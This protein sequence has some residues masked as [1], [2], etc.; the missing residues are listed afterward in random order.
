M[1]FSKETDYASFSVNNLAITKKK[2][3]GLELVVKK[4]NLHSSLSRRTEEV[5]DLVN[6]YID[7]LNKFEIPVPKIIE[8]SY[9]GRQLVYVSKFEGENLFR[10]FKPENI[11]DSLK[12]K[13]KIIESI[14]QILK[15][16]IDSGIHLDPHPKNFVLKK[17]KVHYVDFTPP[18]SNEYSRLRLSIANEKEKNILKDFFKCFEPKNIIYH[19]L[20]DILKID[21]GLEVYA[22]ELFSIIKAYD[23]S[24]LS[25]EEFL[26]KSKSIIKIEKK[27]EEKNI[28]LL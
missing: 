25:F 3:N 10:I 28:F 8:K 7:N 4:T 11:S 23:D 2:I 20:G 19:F 18:Y 12:S 21:T 6:T 22:K 24:N 9:S 14:L 5:F 26:I 17:S 16:A 27:R 1:T 15:K 13:T